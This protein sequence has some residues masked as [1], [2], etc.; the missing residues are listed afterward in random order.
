MF[1]F[2][3]HSI[4]ELN[5]CEK[6]D[7]GLLNQLCEQASK[8][9]DGEKLLTLIKKISE[10]LDKKHPASDVRDQANKSA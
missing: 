9:T 6:H 10:E 3:I 5:M 8:E 4:C 1:G 2:N 7:P